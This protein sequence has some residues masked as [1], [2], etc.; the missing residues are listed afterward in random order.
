MYYTKDIGITTAVAL[1]MAY[2]IGLL[3]GFGE[4]ILSITLSVFV[5]FILAIK[6]TLAKLVKNL[7]YEEIKSALQIGI[8]AL[9]LLP[10]IP[11]VY[12]P[13][14]NVINVRIFF[15]FLVLVLFI[16]FM[17]Y[18]AIKNLGPAQGL[19]TFSV[20]GA[21]IS[22]EA[23]SINLARICKEGTPH[24][25][26]CVRSIATGILLANVTMVIRTFL[27]AVIL[28][29]YRPDFLFLLGIALSLATIVG[30]ITGYIR[31][32]VIEMV[33]PI[34]AIEL[35]SPL[36]YTT[37]LKFSII[38]TVIV[39]ITVGLQR[40]IPRT[41]IY[42]ASLLGG[43]VSNA[44]VVLSVVSLYISG[45]IPLLTAVQAILIGT[46][47]AVSNKVIYVK[48]ESGDNKLLLKVIVDIV[49]LVV[50]ISLGAYLIE[51][52]Q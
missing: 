43:L 41:G 14:F 22:S 31:L 32:K 18:M 8:L 50:M 52:I 9:L 51:I 34:R 30:L 12:D 2:F 45:E 7:E 27:L 25:K 15:F 4:I 23:V 48:I 38:F 11:D 35:R 29:W 21:M 44:A 42:F 24:E 37:A 36:S 6:Q 28:A 16:G 26:Y 3:V 47:A 13:I 19:M 20:I 10:L 40:L 33:S 1:G 17:A 39:F 5:T 46:A 49:I